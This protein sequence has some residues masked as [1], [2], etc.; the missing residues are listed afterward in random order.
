MALLKQIPRS[1]EARKGRLLELHHG[2]GYLD[3]F[4]Q[5]GS[6]TV[7]VLTLQTMEVTRLLIEAES[8]DHATAIARENMAAAGVLP[9][10]RNVIMTVPG[11]VDRLADANVPADPLSPT[12][13]SAKA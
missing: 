11:V 12:S 7:F 10:E 1:A 13:R 6:F 9:E 5:A 8:A 4:A 2:S 3:R